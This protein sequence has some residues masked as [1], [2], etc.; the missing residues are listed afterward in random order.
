[1][2]DH[3]LLVMLSYHGYDDWFYKKNST[4]S[5]LIYLTRQVDLIGVVKGGIE[6]SNFRVSDFFELN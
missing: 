4:A 5:D 6:Q 1:M 3:D 2:D